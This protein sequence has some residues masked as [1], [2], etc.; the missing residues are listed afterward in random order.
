MGPSHA[1]NGPH[2]VKNCSESICGKCKPNLDKHA[3]DTCPRKHP[4][5]KNQNSSRSYNNNNSNRTKINN[6]T[7]PN[8][9]LSVSTNKPDHMAEL[10]EP[11]RKMTKYLKKSFKHNKPHS[12]VNSNPTRS[13]NHNSSHSDKHK[14]T[15]RNNSDELNE[16]TH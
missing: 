7:K 13:T 14:Q 12:I 5:S 2:L 11:T 15:P 3:P 9:Q 10:L 4:L 8:L 1:C 16:I 6:Y